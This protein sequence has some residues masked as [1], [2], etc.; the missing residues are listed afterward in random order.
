M[1]IEVTGAVE[2]RVTRHRRIGGSHPAGCRV[3]EYVR[4]AAGHTLYSRP[5]KSLVAQPNLE[6]LDGIGDAAGVQLPDGMGGRARQWLHR[7][8]GGYRAMFRVR[9][10]HC[11]W[12]VRPGGPLRK[13]TSLPGFK[14]TWRAGWGEYSEQR[15]LTKTSP[16]QHQTR[17]SKLRRSSGKQDS[18]E[19]TR[20][21]SQPADIAGTVAWWFYSR[22]VVLR[23]GREN[24][25]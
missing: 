17:Q 24:V 4:R 21:K 13:A 9:E 6:M 5:S 10:C 11:L 7:D 16:Y 3:P 2:V 15:I 8:R 23:D 18:P 1:R 20:G 12:L 14:R 19:P 22:L 25:P